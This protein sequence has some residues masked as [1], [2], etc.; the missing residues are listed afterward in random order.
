MEQMRAQAVTVR[1]FYILVISTGNPQ[2]G[3]SEH[4]EGEAYVSNYRIKYANR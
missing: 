2:L 4:I 1:I 3:S